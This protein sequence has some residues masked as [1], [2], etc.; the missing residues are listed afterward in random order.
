M[1]FARTAV[2]VLVVSGCTSFGSVSGGA[3]GGPI[4]AANDAGTSTV[5]AG[6]A[7]VALRSTREPGF[8]C[9]TLAGRVLFAAC[10]DFEAPTREEA[11]AG[12]ALLEENDGAVSLERDSVE[13]GFARSS[14]RSASA[15]ARLRVTF[16]A[17]TSFTVG[18]D[19]KQ[20]TTGLRD[21]HPLLDIGSAMKSSVSVRFDAESL[22]VSV[23][24]VSITQPLDDAWHR[25]VVI[26]RG[27][28]VRVQIDGKDIGIE[29][30]LVAPPSSLSV[31]VGIGKGGGVDDEGRVDIDNLV[32]VRD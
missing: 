25:Y 29:K 1:K 24:D 13:L 32:V 9:S 12:L 19:L 2:F 17:G 18:V 16:A 20:A 8:R 22:S 4:D 3:D 31:T 5:D 6:D 7:S 26:A 11:F 28:A 30:P 10:F 14:V 15:A 23:E 27:G 21:A